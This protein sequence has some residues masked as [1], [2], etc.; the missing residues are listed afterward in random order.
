MLRIGRQRRLRLDVIQLETDVGALCILARPEQH[1]VQYLIEAARLARN[2]L[3]CRETMEAAQEA[4]K[5]VDLGLHAFQGFQ[6]TGWDV[7]LV[8]HRL[9]HCLHAGQR[10]AD[11]VRHTHRQFA[12]RG[13]L[14]HLE[15]LAIQFAAFV[16]DFAFL[17]DVAG[18]DDEP[19]GGWCHRQRNYLLRAFQ[20]TAQSPLPGILGNIFP[21]RPELL[22]VQAHRLM[23]PAQQALGGGV[24]QA[25]HAILVDSQNTV[26]CMLNDGLQRGAFLFQFLR[27]GTNLLL[28]PV[29]MCRNRARRLLKP[30][31]H[32]VEF[33]AQC[34]DLIVA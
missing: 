32:A 8:L 11:F 2:R 20:I 23:R 21:L 12:Q 4:G 33:L 31:G 6:Q 17:A 3:R 25:D 18:D 19:G 34:S 22:D 13:Q 16:L 10:V 14:F 9:R 28:Q 30:R 7:I 15:H 27:A 5:P 24:Q 29:A 26:R 1:I